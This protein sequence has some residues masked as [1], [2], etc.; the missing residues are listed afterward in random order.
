MPRAEDCSRLDSLTISGETNRSALSP[1]T[2]ALGEDKQVPAYT[3]TVP[4]RR[5]RNQIFRNPA[6]VPA[7]HYPLPAS[8]F[9]GHQLR[10]N[11]GEHAGRHSPSPAEAGF[12]KSRTIPGHFPQDFMDKDHF[13]LRRQTD[14]EGPRMTISERNDADLVRPIAR[15]GATHASPLRSPAHVNGRT[16]SVKRS[17]FTDKGLLTRQSPPHSVSD[18]QHSDT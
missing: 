8:R 17:C 2:Q 1:R 13:T 14:V 18:A 4:L 15:A 11:D 16:T 7:T 10:G 3:T 5:G 6:P 9:R 12:R